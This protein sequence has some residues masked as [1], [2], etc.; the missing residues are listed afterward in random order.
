MLGNPKGSLAEGAVV[1]YISE[2]G[3]EKERD[4]GFNSD[5]VTSRPIPFSARV[6]LRM[7]FQYNILRLN[8]DRFV[9]I[10]EEPVEEAITFFL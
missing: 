8:V 10:V 1:S 4:S 2:S 5:P 3:R 9:L 6:C 7:K